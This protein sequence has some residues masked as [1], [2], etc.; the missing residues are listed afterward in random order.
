MTIESDIQKIAPGAL[1]ELFVLDPTE[2]GGSVTRFHA[3]SNALKQPVVWAGDIYQPFPVEASGFEFSGRGTLPQ[4][5]I[6]ISNVT[7]LIGV[8]VRDADDLIGAKLTRKRTFAKYLDAVNFVGGF[9]PTADP[10]AAF[11]DDIFFVNRKATENK[12]YIEFDLA[13]AC[14]VQGVRIPRRVI[15]QN[16]CAWRYRG[17]ECGYAGPPVATVMDVPTSDAVLDNCGKRLVS[18]KF[19]FGA[20]G[21]LPTAAFPGVGLIR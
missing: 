5:K 20:F 18:C 3:G 21:E 2:L 4:P 10:T 15:V 12:V 9:N 17:T 6:R 1:V 8:L 11:P 7:G 16:V 13:A 19:R 14:D